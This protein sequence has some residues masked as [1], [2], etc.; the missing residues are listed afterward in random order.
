[1][2]HS[3]SFRPAVA[4]LSLLLASAVSPAAQ[5]SGIVEFLD[6]RLNLVEGQDSDITVLRSGDSSAEATV[7]LNVSLGGTATLGQDF[8]IDLPLGVIRIPAGQRFG[9]ATLDTLQNNAVDGTRYAVLTLANPSSAVLGRETALLL[10]VQDDEDAPVELSLPGNAVRRVTEGGELPVDVLREGSAEQAVTATVLGVP[11]SAGLGIDFSDLTSTVEFAADQG[12]QQVVLSTIAIAA[13]DHPR[14]LTVVLASPEPE[15]RAAFTGLG[16]LVVIEEP[17]A[18]RAGEFAIFTSTPEVTETDG[19]V[20]FTVDRNRGSSGTATVNWVTVDGSGDGAAVAG[21][22][23][24]AAG[25]TLVFAEGETRKTFEVSLVA[26][27][28]DRRQRRFQVGLAAPSA[29]AGIDPD[30]RAATVTIASDG[31]SDNDCKGFCD[32]F[33]ATAAW[34]SW[35]HPHVKTLR[36][37]RDEVLMPTAPGRA[38]VAF[39]Y[40]HSPP[41]AEFIARH[42]S[43]R[44][45]ARGLL[46][47]VVLAVSHP[48]ATLLVLA[49]A[50]LGAVNL[51]G[52]ARRKRLA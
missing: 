10:Q 47:P 33:I 31:G 7:T 4:A 6:P 20:V 1:M 50:L 36:S 37:F 44:G 52:R 45:L 39:Y 24:V 15:G 9:R 42:E 22:D 14:T 12:E 40:R 35:M 51:R 18:E 43:L 48:L 19:S 46:T 2:P 28:A 23:Y 29:L 38:L 13:P 11:G 41:L 25:G 8:T 49:L 34:G 21:T 17:V 16:P 27:D 30:S 3:P 32:C 5:A 26:G